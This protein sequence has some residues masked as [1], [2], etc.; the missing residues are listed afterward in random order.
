MHTIDSVIKFCK[1]NGVEFL[2]KEYKTVKDEYEFKCSECGEIFKQR[3][4]VFRLRKN[5]KCGKCRKR[6]TWNFES[7]KEYCKS[8][9]SKFLSESFTNSHEKYKFLCSCCNEEIVYVSFKE[10]SRKDK[11]FKI[12]EKCSGKTKWNYEKVVSYCKQIGAEFISKEYKTTKDKYLFSCKECGYI[13]ETTFGSLLNSKKIICN[14][15]SLI[16][17]GKNRQ[18]WT[19]DYIKKY[20]YEN[21]KNMELVKSERKTIKN[22]T[23]RVYLYIKCLDCNSIFKVELNH[24]IEDMRCRVCEIPISSKGETTIENYL[25]KN[26]IQHEREYV[27]KDCKYIRNLRFDFVVFK[28]NIPTHVIEFMGKQHYQ[29]IKYFG[30]LKTFELIKKRDT[31]KV[32]YLKEKNIPQINI[33]YNDINKVEEILKYALGI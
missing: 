21:T 3:Y 16:K 4:D 22:S 32:Q 20:F 9:N 12:C 19:D 7:V 6:K 24:F 1:D 28:N 5:V 10:F 27:F 13:F 25:K 26:N 8:V 18:V 14:K 31:I 11:N 33:K 23:S 29:P 30:G 2:S 17:R 15:C